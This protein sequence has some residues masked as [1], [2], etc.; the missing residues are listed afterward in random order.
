MKYLLS[1]FAALVFVF[2]AF[3]QTTNSQEQPPPPTFNVIS[4]DGKVFN[5]SELKGRIIVLNLWYVNCPFCVEEIKLLNKVVD[6]YQNNKDVVFIGLA[7]DTKPK[8]ESFLKKNP[9][10]FN[11]VAGAGELMLFGFGDQQKNGSYYLPFPTHV[12]IDREGRTVVKT[13]G[14]KGIEA[15]RNEL[16]RQ[17]GAESAKI[18]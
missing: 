15:V 3:G 2:P 12:V 13:A 4:I 18:K 5:S 17:F 8:L 9:F 6:E 14:V 16:K 11:V 7:T 1:F 10:K